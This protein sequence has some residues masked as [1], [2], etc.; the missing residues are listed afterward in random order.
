M[1]QMSVLKNRVKSCFLAASLL[2]ACYLLGPGPL[3]MAS[4]SSEEALRARVEQC[5][6]AFQQGDWPKA[7][8]YLT[9]DSKPIYRS[10][11][12][13]PLLA[14]QIQSIKLE[15]DGRSATVVV[16]VPI[17]SA[18]M[19][20]PMPVPKTTLWR[21]IGHVW[22]ME[23]QSPDS[24]A[25]Q[26]M[27]SALTRRAPPPTPLSISKDLK[28][29]STWC[30]LG[31]VESSATP[32][33][34]FRFTNVSTHVVTLADIQLGCDCLRLKTQQMEYK[35]GESGT[36][37]IE[38]DPASLGLSIEESFSQAVV[39]KTEPGGGYVMLNIGA[40]VVPASAPPAK[41]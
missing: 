19:P 1:S 37:E 32:V 4:S 23:L 26:G 20:R 22:Y 2:A 25:R 33:A 36:L 30:G 7:E 21:L 9:K 13:K 17:V 3:V 11:T 39:L 6:N 35:P 38:F 24:N 40:L 29:E 5:Y 18:A 8:K 41:P 34:R 15:P 16:L 27:F 14:Y 10:Q 28:F 12:K 31:N